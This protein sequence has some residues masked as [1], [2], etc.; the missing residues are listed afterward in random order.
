MLESKFERREA[1]LLKE[2]DSLRSMVLGIVETE[3]GSNSQ[4]PTIPNLQ[5]QQIQSEV[6]QLK[7]SKEQM[8]S[9][10][11]EMRNNMR[12]MEKVSA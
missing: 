1:D 3:N 4:A 5:E 7:S 10:V 6:Q 11:I 9:M 12:E 2:I 8:E